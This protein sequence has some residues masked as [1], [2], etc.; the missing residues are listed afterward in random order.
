MTFFSTHPFFS[1]SLPVAL[2]AIG[3]LLLA[4]TCYGWLA[5]RISKKSKLPP[6]PFTLLDAIAASALGTWFLFLTVTSFGKDQT[7]TLSL[8]LCNELLYFV[9]VSGILSFLAWRHLHPIKLFGLAP[10]QPLKLLGRSW[11]WLLSCYPLIMIGQGVIQILFKTEAE[12]QDIVLYFLNN[13]GWKE[14]L[15]LIIMA[16]I[17]APIAEEFLFRGYLY[18]V[19]RHF[20]GRL[21]AILLTSLLFAAVHLHAPS[22]LGLA[23]LAVI[24][25]LLYEQTGSLWANICV[26]ATFNALSIVMLLLL[27]KGML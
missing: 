8:I 19:L 10:K 24:L 23:L 9:L 13:P 11:L 15:A 27:P 17:V 6:Q 20:A 12:A 18:G 2:G 3:A 5:Y 7:I 4:L 1:C 16:V 25:S 14:R 26:H 21:P 22:F